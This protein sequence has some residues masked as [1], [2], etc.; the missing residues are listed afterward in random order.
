MCAFA[1]SPRSEKIAASQAP[2]QEKCESPLVNRM[3]RRW[4]HPLTRSRVQGAVGEG[5][6]GE[7]EVIPTE[8]NTM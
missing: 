4:V 5:G 3:N 6:V 1:R 8:S 2:S 7:E